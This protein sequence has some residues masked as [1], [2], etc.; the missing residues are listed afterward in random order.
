MKT[1]LP[2]EQPGSCY[3]RVTYRVCVCVPSLIISSVRLQELGGWVYLLS[4]GFG[5]LDQLWGTKEVHCRTLPG[6]CPP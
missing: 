6:S 2:W 4:R 3:V 1:T 5:A